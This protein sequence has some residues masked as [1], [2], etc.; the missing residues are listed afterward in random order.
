[1]K[2]LLFVLPAVA[3][4]FIALSLLRGQHVE[5]TAL[6]ASATLTREPNTG[7]RAAIVVELFT[8]E[9]CSSCPPADA[10]LTQL[11]QAS[12]VNG[13]EI[14]V[15]SEH[16]DYW[17]YIG[18]TDPFSSPKFSAR[19][20]AYAEVFRRTG[21]RG[22]AYTPQ[23]VVDGQ[24]EFIG[25]YPSRAR[26]AIA[27]AANSPKA[28]VKITPVAQAKP[29]A[30]SLRVEVSGLPPLSANDQAEIWLALT[31]NNLAS[32]VIRGENSRRKLPHNGVTRELR[33]LGKFA[34]VQQSFA[35]ETSVSLAANWKRADLRAIAFVQEQGQRR[36]LGAA[37]LKLAEIN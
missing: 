17:N 3:V 27:K 22:E 23:M 14:I 31:E 32:N 25:S 13:A 37:S 7:T 21:G 19:Q 1:M 15:L 6:I 20:Q 30:L 26:E 29:G 36:I 9:G 35:A 2:A 28:S 4:L 5:N 11:D 10:L 8:S 34:P 16:V 33:A 18:W 24:F 12:P